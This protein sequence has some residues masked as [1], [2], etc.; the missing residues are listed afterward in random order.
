MS[1]NPDCNGCFYQEADPRD[2]PCNSCFATAKYVH[3]D[4]FKDVD[5]NPVFKQTGKLSW[6]FKPAD[7]LRETFAGKTGYD[8]VNKPKHYMLFDEG[9]VVFFADNDKGIEVRDV[10]EQLVGKLEE[11]DK[12]PMRYDAPLFTADY[13][14]MMQYL[15][16][17]MDKNGVED[18][19]KARWYLDK[20]IES[21]E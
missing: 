10:I 2:A 4:V 14:Q 1:K 19:K 5:N 21:Y 18:L 8:T 12:T 11:A 13:V 16:R 17:F 15:M 3:R 7:A 6:E 9:T 20:M